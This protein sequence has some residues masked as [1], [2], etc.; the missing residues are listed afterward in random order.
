MNG[1][2]ESLSGSSSSKL[3]GWGLLAPLGFAF[4]VGMA[5]AVNPCGF[6]MLPAYLGL[7]LGDQEK[8]GPKV[9]PGKR[10][11]HALVVGG[12]VTAGF[13]V[14]FGAAGLIIGLGARTLI[15][16]VLPWLGLVIGVVLALVG[17][18]MIGGG[19]LY[20]GIAARAANNMG[21]PGTVSL[22]GYLIFGISYATASLSCTLLIF[23]AVV[24]TSLAVSSI[25][26]SLGQFLLY[27]L[28]MG[29]VITALTVGM[30]FFKGAMVGALR[31]ALPYVQPVGSWLMVIAG[32]YIVFYWLTIGDLL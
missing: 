9:H 31:K 6:A 29:V 27:A 4:A 25:F 30:A 11:V 28:G 18:W 5:S 23:L 24:G 12:T 13:V 20:T 15:I 21:D 1:F 10:L 16:E 32:M 14:L 8:E 19:K 3:G 26:T 17:S 7:Y 22:K 2:V